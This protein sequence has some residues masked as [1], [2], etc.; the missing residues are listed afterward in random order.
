[1]GRFRRNA[2]RHCGRVK[3]DLSKEWRTACVAG[4]PKGHPEW[5][6]LSGM[7]TGHAVTVVTGTSDIQKPPPPSALSRNDLND[8]ERSPE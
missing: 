3:R 5:N 2:A 6:Y 7:T 4:K 8:D 1:M